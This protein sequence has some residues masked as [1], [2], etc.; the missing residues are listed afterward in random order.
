M[1]KKDFPEWLAGKDNYAYQTL[2]HA[3]IEP[4]AVADFYYGEVIDHKTH[5]DQIK[6]VPDWEMERTLRR[7]KDGL[8]KVTAV[9][10]EQKE[11]HQKKLEEI[12]KRGW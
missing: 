2:G 11:H 8:D 3:D 12:L 9:T 6:K 7:W 4:L 5:Y 1:L 10:S